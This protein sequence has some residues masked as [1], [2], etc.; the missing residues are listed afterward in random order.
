LFPVVFTA[1]LAGMRRWNLPR[2]CLLVLGLIVVLGMSLSAVQASRMAGNMS[3]AG[4]DGYR[5]MPGDAKTNNC[6]AA[7]VTPVAA[8]VPQV[9]ILLIERPLEHCD[10]L[11]AIGIPWSASPNPHPPKFVA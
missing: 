6:N 10:A 9:P 7:C 11:S 3:M 2:A 5:D 4:C 8:I 1:T